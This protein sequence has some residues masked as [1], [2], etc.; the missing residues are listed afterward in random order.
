MSEIDR[1]EMEKLI[2]ELQG[3]KE[4]EPSLEGK[5]YGIA[6]AAIQ[7]YLDMISGEIVFSRASDIKEYRLLLLI[8][9]VFEEMP[10][11]SVVAN[12][13]H[14]KRSEAK[15]LIKNVDAKYRRKLTK[16]KK[17]TLCSIIDGIDTQEKTSYFEFY[18]DSPCKIDNLN[19]LVSSEDEIIQRVPFKMNRY[20]INADTLNSLKTK[21]E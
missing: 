5:E 13:F 19:D 8:E 11:E 3:L 7:E 14:L 20:R 16:I 15:T 9:N 4:I 1:N 12:L 2:E 17:K 21:L 6:R 10:S 18:C